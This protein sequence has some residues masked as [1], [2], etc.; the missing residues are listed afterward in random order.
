MFRF[1]I[2]ALP[3]LAPRMFPNARCANGLLLSL[4]TWGNDRHF[5]RRGFVGDLINIAWRGML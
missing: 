2:G 1:F 4:V 3:W 5:K